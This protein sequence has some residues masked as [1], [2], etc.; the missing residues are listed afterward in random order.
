MFFWQVCK[1]H[2]FG[3]LSNQ[4]FSFKMVKKYLK[5]SQRP[6][7]CV[8]RLVQVSRIFFKTSQNEDVI[9]GVKNHHF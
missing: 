9:G 5:L 6:V 8:K 4:K 2:Q 3:F 1:L 7:Q